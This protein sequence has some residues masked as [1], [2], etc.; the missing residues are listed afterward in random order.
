MIRNTITLPMYLWADLERDP[1]AQDE[2]LLHIESDADV[3]RIF[4]LTGLIPEKE[5]A[6]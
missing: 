4:E 2:L 3:E 5:V 6:G 1:F